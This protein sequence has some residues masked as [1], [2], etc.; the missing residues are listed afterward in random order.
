MVGHLLGILLHNKLVL[1]N[2]ATR[3]CFLPLIDVTVRI[4]LRNCKMMILNASRAHPVLAWH[5][6]RSKGMLPKPGVIFAG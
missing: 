2:R 4:L 6:N 3:I 1:E 5:P